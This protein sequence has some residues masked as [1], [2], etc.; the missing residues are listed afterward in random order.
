MVTHIL[1]LSIC[2]NKVPVEFKQAKMFPLFK[3]GSRLD[4]NNYRPV[5]ILSSLSKI[6][7]KILFD[8]IEEYIS[9]FNILYE[10]QSGFRK[11]HSTETTILYLTDYIKKG[12]DK[13]KL[14]GMVIIA[15]FTKSL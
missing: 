3:K 13:G 4:C 2:Q 14:S 11:L 12:I 15:R 8:Q 7:E 10:F 1:N 6:L 5:S 9:N